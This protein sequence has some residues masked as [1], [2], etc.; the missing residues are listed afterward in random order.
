MTTLSLAIA[1]FSLVSAALLLLLYLWIDFPNKS[2]FSICSCAGLLGALSMIQYGH[3]SY[4]MGG[5]EPLTLGFYKVGLYVAPSA[6]YFFARWAVLPSEAWRPLMLAHLLP[7]GLLFVGR[8]EITLPILF[9]LG[10]GYSLWLGH[11][12]Y[13]LR[14]QRK[15]FQFEFFYFAVVST[16]ALVVLVLGLAIPYI[17]H[18]YFYRFYCV[19]IGGSIAV[20]V[21]ALI[22]NPELIAD[23][24]EAAQVRYGASTL[25]DVDIDTSLKKLDTLMTASKFYQNEDLSLSS[26]ATELG[27]SSHQLSELINARLGVNFSRYVKE[28]RVEAAKNLL[29]SAPSQSILS[30]S[31]DTGFRSQSSFYAAFKE[32]TGQSPGDYRKARQK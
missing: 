14:A 20:M 19:S 26:L 6:F 5:N 7:I 2:V 18:D 9:M 1:G 3:L 21:A 28:R 10:A 32:I 16:I 8:Q 12:V 30:I 13:A 25:K 17:D 31:M 23:L 4:Y 27:L 22:A 15:Q 24:T 29:L 11:M